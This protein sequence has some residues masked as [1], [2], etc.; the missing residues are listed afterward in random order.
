MRSYGK[1]VLQRGPRM[2]TP[3][4]FISIGDFVLW[5][6]R[7]RLC[8]GFLRLCGRAVR[9]APGALPEPFLIV[10]EYTLAQRQPTA[11]TAEFAVRKVRIRMAL[12]AADIILKGTWVDAGNGKV[13]VITPREFRTLS[14]V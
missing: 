11:C 6:S 10:E 5:K 7:G 1:R 9:A 12:N 4:G 3:I 13:I 14:G 8:G 2:A